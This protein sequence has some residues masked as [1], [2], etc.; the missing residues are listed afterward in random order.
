MYSIK[1]AEFCTD[2]G[3][4]TI[5]LLSPNAVQQVSKTLA[6]IPSTV[7]HPFPV[8]MRYFMAKEKDFRAIYADFIKHRELLQQGEAPIFLR[9]DHQ[10]LMCIV[11]MKF[12]AVKGTYRRYR[13]SDEQNDADEIKKIRKTMTECMQVYYRGLPQL[14]M[15]ALYHG[16]SLSQTTSTQGGDLG[17][18]RS[19]SFQQRSDRLDQSLRDNLSGATD[20]VSSKAVPFAIFRPTYYLPE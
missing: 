1:D 9:G 19:E 16:I 10:K 7:E 18:P 5:S 11:G 3:V 14:D 8:L 15:L 6:Q 12:R 4:K 2:R 20:Y 17:A 13:A